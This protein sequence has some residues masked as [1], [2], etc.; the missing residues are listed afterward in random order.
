MTCNVQ[1][2]GGKKELNLRISFED[3]MQRDMTSELKDGES[4]CYN[5]QQK[6]LTVEPLNNVTFV[7]SYSVHYRE[8]S[9]LRRL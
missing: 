3:K 4:F 7:T 8:V 2:V 9:F 6:M 5:V 1:T